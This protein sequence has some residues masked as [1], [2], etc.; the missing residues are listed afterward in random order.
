MVHGFRFE[1]VVLGE[2]VMKKRTIGVV[3]LRGVVVVPHGIASIQ[4]TNNQS[5]HG[6]S[7]AE[8]KGN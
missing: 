4:V 1:V 8:Q 7:A 5:W 3:V 6:S 2:E